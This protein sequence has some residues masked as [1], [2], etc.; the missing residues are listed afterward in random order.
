[1]IKK[2]TAI[3]LI[4]TAVAL[5]ACIFFVFHAV[6]ANPLNVKLIQVPERIFESRSPATGVFSFN[7][8][9]DR[10]VLTFVGSY[11]YSEHYILEYDYK[12]FPF[13][14]AEEPAR[15]SDYYTY[16]YFKIDEVIYGETKMKGKTV[17]VIIRNFPE[18]VQANEIILRG[19]AEYLI[20]AQEFYGMYGYAP[21]IF[22]EI[23]AVYTSSLAACIHPI[24]ER[25]VLIKKL[26]N[27]DEQL[28]FI[29]NAELTEYEITGGI[30]SFH[31]TDKST[32][33][34]YIKDYKNNQP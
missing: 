20:C 9:I 26:T 31:K 28:D 32:L 3:F 10:D 18:Q 23:N 8:L 1:M 34:N 25:H 5:T 2:R 17:P 33:I 30:A 12:G 6:T 13:E 4:T 11:L 19:N 14:D 7:Q 16:L 29:K 24:T 22:K 21:E 15:F 27:E